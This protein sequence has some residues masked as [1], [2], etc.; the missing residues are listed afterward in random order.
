ML[1]NISKF[2]PPRRLQIPFLSLSLLLAVGV[3]GEQT[4]PVLSNQVDPETEPTSIALSEDFS[5]STDAS[6]Q[7]ISSP[8]LLSRL[9]EVREQRSQLVYSQQLSELAS[10]ATLPKKNNKTAP[11][12]TVESIET[13]KAAKDARVM[14]RA[15]FPTKD[16]IYLY[17]Q[18]PEPN[19]L[20]QGYVLFQKQQNKVIGALYM[21]NS[22]F[23]CFQGTLERSGELAMTV[24][25]FPDEGGL[26]QVAT[27]NGIPRIN[28]DEPIT[29]AYSVALQDY[30]PLKSISVNDRRMLK[31]CNQSSTGI[32]TKLVK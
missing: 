19:Q 28:E 8:S 18:S 25:S 6:R 20:G 7:S 24:N 17:G 12:T 1:N 26:T 14:P 10:S 9:R 11:T 15:N 21:P 5:I 32:Y 22:E 13:Q 16:G 23:S 27:S 4:K 30:H 2:F 29:Y 3:V 31:M